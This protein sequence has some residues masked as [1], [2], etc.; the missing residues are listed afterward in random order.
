MVQTIVNSLK[1]VPKE[2]LTVII[3][4]LPVSELRGAIPVALMSGIPP[5]KAY[6]LSVIGNMLPVLPILIFLEPVS[7]R[8]RHFKFCAKFFDWLFARAKKK[9]DLIQKY[10]AIGLMLF[11]AIPLPITGAWTGCVAA[12]LF[13]VKLRYAV[14]AVF[15]GVILAGLIV[16]SVCLFGKSSFAFFLAK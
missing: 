6:I 8:L 4:A 5:V 10:E 7:N 13:K 11:V 1:G 12:S 15:A 2:W 9:G 14:P 3:A 16:L